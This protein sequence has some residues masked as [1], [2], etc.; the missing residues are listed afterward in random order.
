MGN[1]VTAYMNAG[2]QLDIAQRIAG[3]SS[4]FLEQNLKN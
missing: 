4:F 1:G 3:R 2:G